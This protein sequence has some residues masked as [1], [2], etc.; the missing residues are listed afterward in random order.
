M[1]VICIS[2]ARIV[3]GVGV[4]LIIGLSVTYSIARGK[5]R[6]VSFGRY[7]SLMTLVYSVTLTTKA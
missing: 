4:G 6:Y 5:R 3:C 7:A 1:L 2:N